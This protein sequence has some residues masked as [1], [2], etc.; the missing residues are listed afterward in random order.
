MIK[1]ANPQQKADIPYV[2]GKQTVELRSPDGSADVY[3]LL[4]SIAIASRYG[5]KMRDALSFAKEKYVNVN[6][7]KPENKEKL[8]SL[9]KLPASC[10]ESAKSLNEMRG[11]FEEDGI[12]PTGT[13]DNIIHKLKSYNDKNLSERLYGKN[14]EIRKLVT[15]FLHCK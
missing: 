14:D 3:M 7:F 1:D 2:E 12:F 5:L 4:A 9:E 15:D 13:I 11:F 8:V 10:Y 6:I